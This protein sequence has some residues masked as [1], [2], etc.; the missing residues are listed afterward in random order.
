MP[1][2]LLVNYVILV[3]VTLVLVLSNCIISIFNLYLGL[4]EH[5]Y[6]SKNTPTHRRR[7][8]LT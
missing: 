7:G 2:F 4:S 8:M 1:V 5:P 3:C 6:E